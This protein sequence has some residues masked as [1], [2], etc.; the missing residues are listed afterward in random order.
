MQVNDNCEIFT[1]TLTNHRQKERK[2]RKDWTKKVDS[3]KRE[4]KII[5]DCSATDTLA[6]YRQTDK[7][8]SIQTDRQKSIKITDRQ[9][10]E[11]FY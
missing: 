7:Q 1:D 6:K 9:T 4:S 8:T 3:E 11:H 10:I 2:I 5:K